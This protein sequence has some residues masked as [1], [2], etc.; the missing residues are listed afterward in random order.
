MNAIAIP[1]HR[2]VETGRGTGRSQIRAG[3]RGDGLAGY[4]N[5]GKPTS[6]GEVVTNGGWDCQAEFNG[7]SLHDP[8]SLRVLSLKRK[9][10]DR[11]CYQ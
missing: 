7:G 8:C 10:P 9:E 5:R 1:E 6:G 3:D 2:K 4:K 11:S